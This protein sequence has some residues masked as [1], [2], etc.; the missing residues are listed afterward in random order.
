[1]KARLFSC[2][3]VLGL[4][5]AAAAAA[6]FREPP[7]TF[8]GSV[9]Y[10][11][12]DGYAFLLTNGQLAWTIQPNGGQPFTIT[13]QLQAVGTSYS[14]RLEIPV[15][16]IAGG[17]TLSP[18][19]IAATL[20]STTY[21]RGAVTLDGMA[22]PITFPA[23]AAA[24]AFSFA[25][26]QRGKMERVDLAFSVSV[27]D[28]DG[29]GIPDWWEN[30]YGLNPFDPSDIDSDGDGETNLAEYRSHTNPLDPS[31]VVHSARALNISTRLH[32]FTGENV[33]IGGFIVTGNDPK[34]VIIR[35]IGPSLA[36]NGIADPLEDPTLE[37]FDS[38]GHSMAF[39]NNWKDSQRAEIEATGIPPDNDAES[40]I[41]RTLPPGS[42]TAVLKG[43]SGKTGLALVEVYDI[44]SAQPE[45]LANISARGF[46][47]TGDNVIIGGFIVGA[48]LGTDGA[49]SARLVVRALGP[50]LG[51]ADVANPLADPTLELFDG[52]GTSLGSNNNWREKQ[53]AELQALGLGPKNDLESALVITVP[54]G[55]YTVVMRGKDGATGV[56]LVEVYS[57]P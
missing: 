7:I 33:L 1:M 49:G 27:L 30:Q 14:Y 6:G 18:G 24:G 50:S 28:T 2:V 16:K 26:S 9:T 56:G 17:F 43:D 10:N 5:V 46:V 48:G 22:V 23:G 47:D 29:D 3:L 38:T 15:E 34:S 25:E 13:T 51:S 36:A 57:V 41:V 19:T 20:S 54:K 31:S 53:Q 40:A 52:Q 45:K 32:V 12:P 39:N 11:Y 35:G 8:Y 21:T 44:S 42:Y 37:L 55:A 4:T